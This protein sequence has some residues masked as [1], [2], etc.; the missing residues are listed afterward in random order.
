MKVDVAGRRTFS[1]QWKMNIV[2]QAAISFRS[3]S[4]IAR[5]NSINT[6]QVFR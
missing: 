4:L 5:E 2:N 3:V 6:N 1:P